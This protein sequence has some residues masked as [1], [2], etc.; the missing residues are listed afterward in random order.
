MTALSMDGSA[1]DSCQNKKLLELTDKKFFNMIAP[2][3]KRHL[4][5]NPVFQRDCGDINALVDSIVKGG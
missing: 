4:A 3:L 5:R 2:H 1:F